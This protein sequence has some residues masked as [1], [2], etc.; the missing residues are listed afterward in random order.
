MMDVLASGRGGSVGPE[1]QENM[2]ELTPSV[3]DLNVNASFGS[4]GNK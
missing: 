3:Q 1:Q 4:S 2:Q